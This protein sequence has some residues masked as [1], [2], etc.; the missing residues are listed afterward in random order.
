MDYISKFVSGFCVTP[1]KPFI[2]LCITLQMKGCA[3]RTFQQSDSKGHF[4]KPVGKKLTPGSLFPI[5]E[6][7]PTRGVIVAAALLDTGSAPA[8]Y[9]VNSK[10]MLQEFVTS[11]V[12]ELLVT[13]ST[14]TRW[15]NTP[16]KSLFPSNLSVSFVKAKLDG[17]LSPWAR[18]WAPIFARNKETKQ[19]VALDFNYDTKATALDTLAVPI[20]AQLGIERYSIP[21]YL[22]GGNFMASGNG[23]CFMSEKVLEDN[24]KKLS[25]WNKTFNETSLTKLFQDS[26]GCRRVTFLPKM[27]FEATGHIDIWAKLVSDD[28][29]LISSLPETVTGLYLDRKRMLEATKIKFE[30]LG[31]KVVALPMAWAHTS[32]IRSYTNSLLLNGTALIPSYADDFLGSEEAHMREVEVEVGKVFEEIG[33]RAKFIP[34]GEVARAKGALHCTTMQIPK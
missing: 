28:T 9:E 18:D 12:T 1:L 10:K 15:L 4:E 2:L 30:S 20:A 29:V 21:V 16:S 14:S 24:S 33:F 19:I 3:V 11:G 8:L 7:A 5:A 26:V 13:E 27:P 25:F 31:Y 23:D 32:G 22:E 34:F 6:Y 17:N